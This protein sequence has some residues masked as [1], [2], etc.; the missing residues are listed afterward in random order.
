MNPERMKARGIKFV[1]YEKATLRNSILKF[2]KRALSDGEGFANIEFRANKEVEG[3]LYELSNHWQIFLLDRFEGYPNHYKR[4]E[5]IVKT[6]NGF[7]YAYIYKA[8]QRFIQRGLKPSRDYLNHLL[9][10]KE[11]LSEDYYTKLEATQCI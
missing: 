3:I 11:L 8:N 4:F 5:S 10:G 9:A 1:G 2:N 6:S 7:K